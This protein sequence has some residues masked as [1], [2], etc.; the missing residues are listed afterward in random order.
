MTP[1]PFIA[2]LSAPSNKGNTGPSA[3]ALSVAGVVGMQ[4][5]IMHELTALREIVLKAKE[6]CKAKKIK[7]NPD[8]NPYCKA[9]FEAVLNGGKGGLDFVKRS[10]TKSGASSN[11]T[12]NSAL[13]PDSS[14]AQQEGSVWINQVEEE[15][16]FTP[17]HI[18]VLNEDP[19]MIKELL[20]QGADVHAVDKQ[21][22]SPVLYALFLEKIMPLKLLLGTNAFNINSFC[23]RGRALLH[24]ASML[25]SAQMARLILSKGADVN[26][27]STPQQYSPLHFACL[28]GAKLNVACLLEAPKIKVNACTA[29]GTTPYDIVVQKGHIE[30]AGLIKNKIFALTKEL[31]ACI[32]KISVASEPR[33]AALTDKFADQDHLPEQSAIEQFKKVF[34]NPAALNKLP[35]TEAQAVDVGV[36]QD[37]IFALIEQG[38]DVTLTNPQGMNSLHL[39]ALCGNQA[40]ADAIISRAPD[41]LL[42]SSAVDDRM[43]LD[44]ALMN[45]VDPALWKYLFGQTLAKTDYRKKFDLVLDSFLPT[46]SSPESTPNANKPVLFSGCHLHLARLTAEGE[47]AKIK[48]ASR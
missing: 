16:G 46:P 10:S 30:I 41:L 24:W 19:D 12:A 5:K 42:E 33:L 29:A 37:R 22:F 7:A 9:F 1:N 6:Y 31:W 35:A 11:T 40:M 21:G 25:P 8:I 36:I 38:A 17:L 48:I 39:V 28:A 2:E 34:L 47:K 23:F 26:L 44:Y 20:A 18:A 14:K 43:P 3:V 4:A 13:T 45:I 15:T 32:I 27:L